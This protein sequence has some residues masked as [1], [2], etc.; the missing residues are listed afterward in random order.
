MSDAEELENQGF[1]VKDRRR[2]HPDG[3]PIEGAEDAA[4]SASAAASEPTEPK[5][6]PAD[7]VEPPPREIPAD[8]SSLILSIAAG[9]HSGLGLAPH[10]MTGKLEKNLSQAKYNIDL[11]GLL[12]DKTKG[13]LSPE[14]AQLVE[15]I[16]YDL[17][18]RY[19]EA[20][21]SS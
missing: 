1:K 20:Q 11:L 3:S 16:L 15:A 8:F 14:E 9:A 19:V 17:R 5:A 12:Q 18:M 13:N 6:P 21:K 7:K 10:P 2:F 4:G